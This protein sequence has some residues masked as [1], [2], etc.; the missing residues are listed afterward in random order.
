MI[1][2]PSI[3]QQ[4]LAVW[5][6]SS[7][8][9]QR[10]LGALIQLLSSSGP[11]CKNVALDLEGLVHTCSWLTHSVAV[12]KMPILRALLCLEWIPL[13]RWRGWREVID[14]GAQ[15]RPERPTPW[16]PLGGISGHLSKSLRLSCS[17]ALSSFVPSKYLS[18]LGQVLGIVRCQARW[19]PCTMTSPS[20]I[21][22][23]HGGEEDAYRWMQTDLQ[24][25]ALGTHSRVHTESGAL[26]KRASLNQGLTRSCSLVS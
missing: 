12:R 23:P 13:R 1:L 11:M 14:Q 15:T 2:C 10:P 25:E 22:L 24:E 9:I 26:G 16:L 3:P 6:V 4:T 19:W 21:C 17:Y 20:G 7:Q 8:G 5:P 18:P